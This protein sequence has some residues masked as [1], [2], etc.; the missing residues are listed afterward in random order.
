MSKAQVATARDPRGPNERRHMQIET[1]S[2]TENNGNQNKTQSIRRLKKKKKTISV[3]L[4]PH[5]TSDTSFSGFCLVSTPGHTGRRPWESLREAGANTHP[6]AGP[7]RSTAGPAP[8]CTPAWRCF[9][10]LGRRHPLP[11][12]GL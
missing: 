11:S 7:Q 8:A 4:L 6:S 12:P 1:T 2:I 5:S 9:H 3:V 10:K